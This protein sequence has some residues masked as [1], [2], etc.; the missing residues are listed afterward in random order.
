MR[1]SSTGARASTPVAAAIEW[2]GVGCCVANRAGA[3]GA[4]PPPGGPICAARRPTSRLPPSRPACCV[5]LAAALLGCSSSSSS[6][7]AAL[8]RHRVAG[9]VGDGVAAGQDLVRL[10]VRD[11]NRKLLLRGRA[12]RRVVERGRLRDDGRH[13]LVGLVGTWQEPRARVHSRSASAGAAGTRRRQGIKH[14]SPIADAPC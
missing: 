10:A 5:R 3:Q 9:D 7:S 2:G 4:W 1:C 8:P 14:A 6:C 12:S 13:R 11:L